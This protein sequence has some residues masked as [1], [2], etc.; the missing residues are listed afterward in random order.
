MNTPQ[1]IQR[2]RTR[3]WR[4]PPGVVYVGRPGPFGNPLPTAE[5]FALFLSDRRYRRF[6]HLLWPGIT[7][8]SDAEI[9]RVLAGK[10]LACWCPLD[11]PCHADVLL[12]LAAQTEG[13]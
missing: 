13:S 12:R 8:P 10:T 6:A 4:M 9:R 7:Y 11:R 1:R 2:R 5:R 3:G